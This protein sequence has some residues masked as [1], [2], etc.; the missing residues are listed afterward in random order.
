MMIPSLLKLRNISDDMREYW[1]DRGYF[2]IDPVQLLALRT[3]TPFF[4]NYDANAGT[5]INRFISERSAPVRATSSE[6]DM[7]CGVTVPIHLPRGDCAT[8]TGIRFGQDKQFQRD[9]DA[10]WR[11]SACWPMFSRSGLRSL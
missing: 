6:R 4:W 9:A 2:R 7:S 3:T 8:V 11:I 5:L 1:F 10:T